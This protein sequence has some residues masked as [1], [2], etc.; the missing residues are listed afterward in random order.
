[1]WWHGGGEKMAR[2]APGRRHSKLG[3]LGE[4]REEWRKTEGVSEDVKMT[5]CLLFAARMIRKA[6]AGILYALLSAILT[7][8]L[9]E[10]V[11]E[12]EIL[13]LVLRDAFFTVYICKAV[14][15]PQ[16]TS[17]SASW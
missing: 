10:A 11:M 7:Y 17:V 13:P 3:V 9:Y 16:S 2:V 8:I 1:M 12:V 15:I 4:E 5:L 14:F 6:A